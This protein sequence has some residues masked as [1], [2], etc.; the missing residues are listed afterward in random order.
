[1]LL[2]ATRLECTVQGSTVRAVRFGWGVCGA[3]V[4]GVMWGDVKGGMG[5]WKVFVVVYCGVL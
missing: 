2:V 4:C 5:S 3:M 1:M